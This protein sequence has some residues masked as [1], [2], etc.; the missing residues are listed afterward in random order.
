MSGIAVLFALLPLATAARGQH[1]LRHP[2]DAVEIRYARSQ[3][4]VCYTL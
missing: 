4:V 3:P 2:V 1:P